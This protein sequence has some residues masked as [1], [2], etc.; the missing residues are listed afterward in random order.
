MNPLPSVEFP[1]Q[2]WTCGAAGHEDA[3]RERQTPSRGEGWR[4][5]RPGEF[6]REMWQER[7]CKHRYGPK[8]LGG[9]RVW[10]FLLWKHRWL[11]QVPLVQPTLQRESE[12]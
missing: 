11:V 1:R 12:P 9:F 6:L 4:E 10:T 3:P 2:A 8:A 7:P 5:G